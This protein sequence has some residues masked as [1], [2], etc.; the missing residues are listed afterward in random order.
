MKIFGITC[1]LVS[2][3]LN[4][5]SGYLVKKDDYDY[6]DIG[7]NEYG[8][9]NASTECKTQVQRSLKCLRKIESDIGSKT[10]YL[11]D[12]GNDIINICNPTNTDTSAEKCKN[13]ITEGINMVCKVFENDECSDLIADNSVVDLIKSSKC[14]SNEY[15]IILIGK[16]A[17]VKTAYLMGCK[18][19]KSGDF[20]PLTKYVT[21]TAIDYAFK[22]KNTLSKMGKFRYDKDNNNELESALDFGNDVLTILPVLKDISN[23][24]IDSCSDASCNKNIL[25]ID[26]MVVA[27]KEAYEKN[28]KVNLNDKYPKVFEYYD[29]YLNIYRN[30]KCS[31]IPTIGD[32]SGV[33]T[34]KKLSYSLVAMTAA[35]ILLLL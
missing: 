21:T 11:Y 26:S 31:M 15:D 20:C 14:E 10:E 16:I 13:M 34:I 23:I 6:F 24:L 1:L 27:A 8:M 7:D 33:S 12:L 29:K 30:K 3:G 2:L 5:A 18:K 17:A 28:Q 19:S 22:N 4:L 32:S 35:S 25:A 9:K